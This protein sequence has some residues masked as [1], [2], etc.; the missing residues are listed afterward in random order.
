MRSVSPSYNQTRRTNNKKNSRCEA[1]LQIT[2]PAEQQHWLSRWWFRCLSR[3]LYRQTDRNIHEY[4]SI[5]PSEAAVR[6]SQTQGASGIG[7]HPDLNSVV[8]H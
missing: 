4:R 2:H 6:R 5:G 8:T 7:L 3:W 1:K